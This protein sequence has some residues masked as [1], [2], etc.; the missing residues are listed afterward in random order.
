[1]KGETKKVVLASRL[2]MFTV[3]LT[4]VLCFLMVG[5]VFFPGFTYYVN[6]Y[7]IVPGVTSSVLTVWYW[8]TLVIV[9]VL[10]AVW[11]FKRVGK[12][13]TE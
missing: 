7:G 11:A 10:V 6:A 9:N 5:V 13:E 4:W 3:V 8:L 2:V 1:M 12:W